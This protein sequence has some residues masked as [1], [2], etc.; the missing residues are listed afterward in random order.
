M[1]AEVLTRALEH[2]YIGSK[3]TYKNS[4]TMVETGEI[5]LQDFREKTGFS[6]RS[7]VI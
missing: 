6:V 5:R 2:S 3:T 7:S 1:S 4:L